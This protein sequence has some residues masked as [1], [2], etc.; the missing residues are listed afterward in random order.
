MN[1]TKG[2]HFSLQQMSEEVW[3]QASGQNHVLQVENQFFNL[4]LSQQEAHPPSLNILGLRFN[5][6]YFKRTGTS[7]IDFLTAD[8]M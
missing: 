6:L 7:N 1:G 4:A 5:S 8:V 2:K 3:D